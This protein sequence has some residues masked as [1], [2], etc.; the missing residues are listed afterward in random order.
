MVD[1]EGTALEMLGK[2][3][4]VTFLKFAI[5][6]IV[7]GTSTLDLGNQFGSISSLDKGSVGDVNVGIKLALTWADGLEDTVPLFDPATKILGVV[8]SVGRATM[9]DHLREQLMGHN[10]VQRLEGSLTPWGDGTFATKEAVKLLE[11]DDSCLGDFNRKFVLVPGRGPAGL[12]RGATGLGSR[13]TLGA[14]LSTLSSALGA[15]FG[16]T[17]GPALGRYTGSG[18]S[19][20]SSRGRSRGTAPV[21]QLDLAGEPVDGHLLGS[22]DVALAIENGFVLCQLG[23]SRFNNLP[24]LLSLML[25]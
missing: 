21:G 6:E 15:T 18:R 17:L 23:E 16:S 14:A 13:G 12:V 20:D 8:W 5:T 25:L 10:N 22:I 1:R 19:T 3:L 4:D 2:F 24:E 9:A 7:N 11:L